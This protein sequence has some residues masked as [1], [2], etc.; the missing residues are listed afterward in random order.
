MHHAI[1]CQCAS[2]LSENGLT[3]K[4]LVS[5]GMWFTLWSIGTKTDT[6]NTWNVRYGKQGKYYVWKQTLQTLKM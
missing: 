2:V 4:I 1:F 5:L 6:A 3:Y